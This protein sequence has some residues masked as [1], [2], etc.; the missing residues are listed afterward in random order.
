MHTPLKVTFH[1]DTPVAVSA[2][3]L[4]LDALIAFAVTRR[5]IGMGDFA[6]MPE[7]QIRELSAKLPLAQEVRNGQPVWQASALVCADP[8]EQ[9]VRMWTRKTNPYDYASRVA[10]GSLEVGVR[11]QNALKREELYVGTIDT[12]RGLLKNQFEFYPLVEMRSLE[13][14]C[15]GDIDEIESLLAPEAG[16]ITHIGKRGR[17]GHGRV[18]SVEVEVCDEA[19]DLWKLRILPWQESKDYEPVLA[20]VRPPYWANEN[21]IMGYYPIS[22]M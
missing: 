16:L 6:N 8:G 3:P 15:V 21:R 10:D 7:Q 11:T 1:L 9:S 4:H 20:A 18:S 19:N 2:Y 12:V 22:L 13:A 5:E 14:W 17:A